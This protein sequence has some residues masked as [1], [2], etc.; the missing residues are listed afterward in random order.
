MK[1][2]MKIKLVQAMVIAIV[3]TLLMQPAAMLGFGTYM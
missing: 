1:D 2:S 3:L